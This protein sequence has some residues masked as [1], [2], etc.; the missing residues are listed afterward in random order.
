MKEGWE[1]KRLGEVCEITMGQSPSSESYNDI[2]RG[3]PFFQGCSDFG[4]LYPH[5]TTYCDM[6]KKMADI[7]DV[8]IS[9]RA[10]IGTLNI[11]NLHCCIGRG[12]ASVR[13][14]KGLSCYKYLY[15]FLLKSKEELQEKGTGATFKAIGK[16]ALLNFPILVPSIEEQSRIVEELDL[17]SNII[18]KKRQQLSELDNL[19]QSIFYD[20]FGDIYGNKYGFEIKEL[21]EVFEFIKD[22]THQTPQYVDENNGVKFLS[23]KDVVKGFIDWSNI[24]YI[25]QELH[26]QLSKRVSPMRNDILLCKNGTYGICALVETDEIFDI[27]VSLALMR[28]KKGYLPK[29]LVYAINN[30]ITKE[31]FNKSIK[32]VGVPNLHLGEIKKTRIIIPPLSLQ[33]LFA[34]KIEAIEKEKELIKQSIAETE[35]LFNSRMDYYFS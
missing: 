25:S 8:L 5:V 29:Y 23:A 7:N 28:P 6:P 1:V 3:M 22:G 15:F 27:Y 11:A 19:A 35:E 24:K 13:E 32:G 12:L 18:E 16:D 2:G 33:Q 20:M 10:P 9:V 26:L 31:Q 4:K 30:P 14:I 17:L 34:K 21:N